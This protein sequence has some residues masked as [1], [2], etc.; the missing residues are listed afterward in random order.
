MASLAALAGSASAS[1]DSYSLDWDEIRERTEVVRLTSTG[2][3]TTLVDN[4]TPG[5]G[6]GDQI[7]VTANL[8]RRGASYGTE[9]AVCTRVAAQTTHCT[10][11]F[12]LPRGQLT[13]QHLKTTAV[14]T[15]PSDFDV[16]ITGGTGAYAT[17]RGYAHIG[18]IAQSGGVLTLHLL[19]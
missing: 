12:S 2:T 10:G 19:H 18:R 4:G 16:A 3:G 13:W 17:V 15:P 6:I 11:T 8:A 14:G 1:H 7:I 9:G 5:V